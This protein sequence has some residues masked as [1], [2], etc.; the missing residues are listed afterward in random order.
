[1]D[2]FTIHCD[3]S[4]HLSS[5]FDAISLVDVMDSKDAV[6]LALIKRPDLGVTFTKLN[7][8][9]LTQYTKCVFLD[10]DTMVRCAGRKS[11]AHTRVLY[12]W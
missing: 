5:V 3:Y 4:E 8:W 12:R 6:N 7:C 11:G 9:R 2:C 10:A 1:M